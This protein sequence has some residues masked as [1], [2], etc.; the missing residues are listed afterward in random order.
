MM[1]KPLYTVRFSQQNKRKK[2]PVLLT[3][4]GSNYK[5]LCEFL[6]KK[7]KHFWCKNIVKKKKTMNTFLKTKND[8]A[9]YFPIHMINK[10]D[11]TDK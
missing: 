10:H 9:L 11:E 7:M 4:L 1:R 8:K 3:L 2:F 5:L 6:G